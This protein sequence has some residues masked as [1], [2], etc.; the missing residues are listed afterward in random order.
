VLGDIFGAITGSTKAAKKAAAETKAAAKLAEFKPFDIEGSI[1]SDVEFGEDTAKYTLSPEL[2]KIRDSFFEG[3][4][5]FSDATKTASLDASKLR[6]YGRGL[7]DSATSRDTDELAGDYYRRALGILEPSR[8]AEQ[9]ALANNLFNT[10]T[11]GLAMATGTGGYA[12]PDRMAYLTSKDRQD[13]RIAF[14]AMD[15]ARNENIQDINR[16]IGLFP[17]ANAIQSDP[18]NYMNQMFGYGS[19]VELQG[20]QPMMLGM[21]FGQAAQPGRMA[22]A[23]GYSNAAQM[24]LAAS[25]ANS[26]MGMDF[27][28]QGFKS[29]MGKGGFFSNLLGKPTDYSSGTTN[30]IPGSYYG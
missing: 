23:Q 30:A 24:P 10:G 7:F 8:I 11:D 27:L 19:G 2:A 18:Y 28:T 29:G 14:E 15:R 21:S 13:E 16:S 3:A 5:Y 4:D 6:D 20:Q 26:A 1:F 9:T 12:N 17:V 22:M 25:L